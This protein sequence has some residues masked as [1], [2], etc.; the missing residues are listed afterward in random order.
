MCHL[1]SSQPSVIRHGLLAKALGREVLLEQQPCH[2]AF[3]GARW[4]T[5]DVEDLQIRR[6]CPVPRMGEEAGQTRQTWP[7]EKVSKS[8]WL[9]QQSGQ[10]RCLQSDKFN[11]EE[12]DGI[13]N[14]VD[15]SVN[16]LLG[17]ARNNATKVLLLSVIVLF[18]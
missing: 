6:E 1:N 13:Q 16:S 7:S 8:Q 5:H 14:L 2:T 12:L 3:A 17:S 9:Q 11:A 15:L 18:C 4:S 10:P